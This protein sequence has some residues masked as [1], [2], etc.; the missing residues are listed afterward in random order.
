MDDGRDDVGQL[1]LLLRSRMGYKN[2]AGAISLF[3]SSTLFTLFNMVSLPHQSST[4]AT[5]SFY[6]PLLTTSRFNLLST[7]STSLSH[8][9]HVFFSSLFRD[10]HLSP[11]LL[12][13]L[14]SSLTSPTSPTLKG[15][16][17]VQSLPPPLPPVASVG[18][19]KRMRKNLPSVLFLN[20]C[21]SSLF[22]RV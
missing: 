3:F 21:I 22:P 15:E 5:Y 13:S 7:S 2:S 16:F 8:L 18:A 14:D 1:Q 6:K 9:G 10:S 12:A 4:V 19:Q 17:T 20:Y 11:P